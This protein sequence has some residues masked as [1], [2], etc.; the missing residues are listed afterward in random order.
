MTHELTWLQGLAVS[1]CFSSRQLASCSN[2]WLLADRIKVAKASG[3]HLAHPRFV[4]MSLFKEVHKLF[5]SLSLCKQQW[6]PQRT[7]LVSSSKKLAS[8]SN[9]WLFASQNGGSKA[10]P[11]TSLLC[12]CLFKEASKFLKSFA[13]CKQTGDSRRLYL[14]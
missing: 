4:C 13:F 9:H 7:S 2:H 10:S 14:A 5:K 1:A 11:G 6:G 12:M 3:P 8:S